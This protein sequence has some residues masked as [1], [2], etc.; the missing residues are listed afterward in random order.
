MNGQENLTIGFEGESGNQSNNERESPAARHQTIDIIAPDESEEDEDNEEKTIVDKMQRRQLS[1]ETNEDDGN[2]SSSSTSLN[3]NGM[4]TNTNTNITKSRKSG[5]ERIIM[6]NEKKTSLLNGVVSNDTQIEFAETSIN[7]KN[8]NNNNNST[9]SKQKHRKKNRNKN[10]HS[11]QQQSKLRKKMNRKKQ[12]RLLSH[13]PLDSDSDN[14]ATNSAASS[15]IDNSDDDTNDDSENESKRNI[16]FETISNP[17]NINNNNNNTNNTM[18]Y[19]NDNVLSLDT[20]DIDINVIKSTVI[21]TKSNINDKNVETS[22]NIGNNDNNNNNSNNNNSEEQSIAGATRQGGDMKVTFDENADDWLESG[23]NLNEFDA[24]YFF[25]NENSWNGMQLKNDGFW[26]RL[27]KRLCV[28]YNE[29]RIIEQFGGK[30]A[31]CC[32]G[33]VFAGVPSQYCTL[34]F[35]FVLILAPLAG[36]YFVAYE[37][38]WVATKQLFSLI[39]VLLVSAPLTFF[40]LYFLLA[41]NLTDPGVVPRCSKDAPMV[42]LCC[43][44][45][46][47]DSVE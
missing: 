22:K 41:T 29:G 16:L 20:D 46:V 45:F 6:I 47:L 11:P 31:I 24:L 1:N 23:L 34:S 21:E 18:D 44:C 28:C 38:F 19:N 9:N 8:S 43:V 14:Y 27:C 25:E 35:T 17:N 42:C 2:E 10:K 4:N 37:Y 36:W 7:N 12:H 40:S 30:N 26:M 39:L 13:S 33:H 5:K 15:N 3:G 32:K